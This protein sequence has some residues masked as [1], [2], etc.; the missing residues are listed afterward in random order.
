LKNSKIAITWV[1]GGIAQ[2]VEHLLETLSSKH[3][4]AKDKKLPGKNNSIIH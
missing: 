2:A 3:S 1:A 4:D